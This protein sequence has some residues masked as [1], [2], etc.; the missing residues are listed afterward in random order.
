LLEG[1]LKIE[2]ESKD[3]AN[4]RFQAMSNEI[5]SLREE[6]RSLERSTPEPFSGRR[7]KE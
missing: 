7:G 1:D 4:E 5:D 3:I 6:L 2:R